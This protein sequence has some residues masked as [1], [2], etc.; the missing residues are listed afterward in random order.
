MFS[1]PTK[2]IHPFVAT[3]SHGIEN[4]R[5]NICSSCSLSAIGSID[6]RKHEFISL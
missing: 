2:N 3:E 6:I 1:S 4:T 5:S